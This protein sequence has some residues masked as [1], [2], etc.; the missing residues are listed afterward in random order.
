PMD[1]RL[2]PSLKLARVTRGGVN[3]AAVPRE[4]GRESPLY[5]GC[6]PSLKLARVTRGGVNRAAVP[7]ERGRASPL[8]KGANHENTSCS[9]IVVH[10]R[11]RVRGRDLVDA[12][13]HQRHGGS[14]V[15]RGH[16]LHGDQVGQ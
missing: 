10:P 8:Y 4:R 13:R 7:R 11:K 1:Q 16:R 3:R 2:P 14:L 15:L 12:E 5:N 6:P 9:G